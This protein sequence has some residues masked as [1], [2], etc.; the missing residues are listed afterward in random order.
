MRLHCLITSVVA[1]TLALGAPVAAR[2][3]TTA[4]KP[5]A[6][7]RYPVCEPSAAIAVSCSNGS[8]AACAW[9]GDNEQDGAHFQYAIDVDGR[10]APAEPFEVSLG[11]AKVGDIEALASDAAGVLVVGSHSRK[12]SCASDDSRIAVVRLAGD[13]VQATRLAGASGF[14]DRKSAC[15]TR[16]LA[17]ADDAPP[18]ARSLRR[19][20][21]AAMAA[22]ERD[23]RAGDPASCAG[24]TLNIEGAVTVPDAS[25]AERLWVGLRAP[26]GQGL[27]VLLRASPL[28]PGGKRL[29]FDGIALIDLRGHGVRELTR[30]GGLVWGIAGSTADSMEKSLLFR[31]R[32][33]RFESGNVIGDTQV[34]AGIELPPTAEG[35][36]VQP[37][38][39]RAIVLLD[40]DTGKSEGACKKKPQQL[41]IT[42]LPD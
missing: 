21:C 35:L 19:D 13:P 11:D 22:A 42:E 8:G 26:L 29:G 14:D 34:V 33:E 10:L 1:L 3:A 17:L 15:E 24:A 39:H 40:G 32:A 30:S 2:A 16:W 38:A 27:G 12:N 37:E 28:K 25:G 20:F 18:A 36:I 7:D 23:A 6:L 4:G 9:I 31:L 5:V 41:T